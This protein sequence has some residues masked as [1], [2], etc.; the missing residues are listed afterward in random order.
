MA[1][2]R[3]SCPNGPAKLAALTELIGWIEQIGS[4]QGI[5]LKSADL[6]C[7]RIEQIRSFQGIL[8]KSADFQCG[9]IE[10]IGSFQEIL[11]KS[12]DKRV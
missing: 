1:L 11:L 8:L 10:Q 3:S 4:F 2:V 7:G 9:R 5:L 6:Q 12:A